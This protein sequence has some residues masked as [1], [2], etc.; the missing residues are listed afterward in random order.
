M[1][2]VKG[3]TLIE[4]MV[5]IGLLAIG[6]TLGVASYS[7]SI[8]RSRTDADVN[9][10][11]HVLSW[12]RLQAINSSQEVSVDAVTDDNWA[13]AI[14]VT[15]DGEIIRSLPGFSAG[16]VVNVTG[17]ISGLVFDSLGGLASPGSTVSFNYT[18]GDQQR[19]VI[20]CPTGRAQSGGQC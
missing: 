19:S 11:V 2:S 17:D 20:L 4:L 3:F 6:L 15:R 12:A 9:E 1:R 8:E 7:G 16:A 5:T 18:R 13:L 10:L 14:S